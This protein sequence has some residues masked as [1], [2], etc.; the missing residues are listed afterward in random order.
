MGCE[1]M[2]VRNFAWFSFL[3]VC[4]ISVPVHAEQLEV[5]GTGACEVILNEL[6]FAFNSYNRENAMIIPSSVGSVG[7]IRLVGT[8]KAQLGRVARPLNEKEKQYGL[9]YC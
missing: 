9:E 7:G 4:I 5:P 2:V 1:Y 3:V 8:G 6:A